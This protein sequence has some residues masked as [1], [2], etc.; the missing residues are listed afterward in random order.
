MTNIASKCVLELC[1]I[2]A[3]ECGRREHGRASLALRHPKCLEVDDL[4]VARHLD[5]RAR[6]APVMDTL[7]DGVPDAVQALR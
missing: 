3:P 6:D 2:F 7:L 4:S 1:L 5:D